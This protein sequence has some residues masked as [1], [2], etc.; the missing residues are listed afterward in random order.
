MTRRSR[1]T[2]KQRDELRA[3]LCDGAQYAA[4][5]AQNYD[6]KGSGGVSEHDGVSDQQLGMGR[7]HAR[8][9]RARR[10]VSAEH[11]GVLALAY[12][13]KARDDRHGSRFPEEISPLLR[14]TDQV[15]MAAASRWFTAERERLI[16]TAQHAEYMR[17]RSRMMAN[18]AGAALAEAVIEPASPAALR[19]LANEVIAEGKADVLSGDEVVPGALDQARDMLEKAEHA[20][21]VALR[22]GEETK[23]EWIDDREYER[24]MVHP[25]SID[26]CGQRKREREAK[27]GAGR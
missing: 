10:Y 6:P 14:L 2:P 25:V 21:L 15:L 8:V 24:P 22:L 5:R 1:L 17:S 26:P 3:Y 11:W 4:L 12:G 13:P 9:S 18:L 19:A 27:E 7:A 20:W 16:V 23:T